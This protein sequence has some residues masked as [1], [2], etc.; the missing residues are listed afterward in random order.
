MRKK[1]SNGTYEGRTK[2]RNGEE[3]VPQQ[4]VQGTTNIFKYKSMIEER[5]VLE[6]YVG[7]EEK[8]ECQYLQEHGSSLSIRIIIRYYDTSNN[9]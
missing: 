6:R 8:K 5:Y 9:T 1:K 3:R 2:E 7:Y 4:R